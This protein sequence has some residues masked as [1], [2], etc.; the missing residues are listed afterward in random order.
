MSKEFEPRL[1][2]SMLNLKD[3]LNTPDLDMIRPHL[4]LAYSHKSSKLTMLSESQKYIDSF[5][6]ISKKGYKWNISQ[7]NL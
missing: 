5:D 7:K 4:V 6:I 1:K 2:S 3:T